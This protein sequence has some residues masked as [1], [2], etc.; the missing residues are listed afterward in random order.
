MH[1]HIVEICSLHWTTYNTHKLSHYRNCIQKQRLTGSVLFSSRSAPPKP[2]RSSPH[3]G[4]SQ[5]AFVPQPPHSACA[6]DWKCGWHNRSGSPRLPCT[7][8]T[9]VRS[10]WGGKARA[11]DRWF[12]QASFLSCLVWFFFLPAEPAIMHSG[13]TFCYFKV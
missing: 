9:R 12:L 6:W 13:S 3:R 5:R 2:G 8:C 1:T 7:L 11:G 4:R 10:P